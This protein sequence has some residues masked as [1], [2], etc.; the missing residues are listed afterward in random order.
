MCFRSWLET[1]EKC[2]CLLNLGAFGVRVYLFE[3][4]AIVVGRFVALTGS[5]RRKGGA[6]EAVEPVR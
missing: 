5:C 6:G 1:A 2:A 3:E 4:F